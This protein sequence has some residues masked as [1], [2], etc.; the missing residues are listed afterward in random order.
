[1]FA[2]K[3]VCDSITPMGS[4]LVTI[5]ITYPRI[6]HSE[7]MTHRDRARNS[8]S[9]RAIPWTRMKS[10]VEENPFVPIVF[11]SEKRGMQPGEPVD[12]EECSKIWLAARDA[13]LEQASKLHNMGVHKSICNRLLEP[14]AWITVVMTATDWKNFFRL[15]VHP[16]AEI[17]FQQIAEM[18]QNTLNKSTPVE[19][20]WGRWHLPYIRGDDLI[21]ASNRNDTIDY[22][23]ILCRISA[24]RCARVS[25][26]THDGRRDHS[27]DLELFDRLV[28]GSGF[29]HWCYDSETEVLTKRG[30]VHWPK[31]VDGDELAQVDLRRA[32]ISFRRPVRIFRSNYEGLMYCVQGHAVDLCV[33]PNHRMVVSNRQSNGIWSDWYFRT[34]GSM[35]D[36]PVRYL[37]SGILEERESVEIPCLSELIGFWFGDGDSYCGKH[38]IRFSL[39]R[40][41]KID[42]LKKF[43]VV[44]YQGGR[45]YVD[46]KNLG[47]WF[48]INCFE[49]GKKCIPWK[50]L[51]ADESFVRGFLDGL[52][53]SDGSV[54]RKTWVFDNTNKQIIDFMQALLHLNGVSASLSVRE[55][56]GKHKSCYRLNVSDRISPRVEINQIS[57]SMSY[58]IEWKKY[59]G[60]I[61]CAEMPLGT[62]IVR[63]NNHV[64]VSGNSPMEHIATPATPDVKSGPF[65]GW[66]QYRKFFRNERAD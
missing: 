48:R 15:R 36:K 11:G 33:T 40:K 42:Y 39:R 41:R 60:M 27:K 35:G 37:K 6:I 57:R 30:W 56:Y 43:A 50:W 66:L 10:N 8:A 7:I 64:V 28:D 2:C 14:F 32:T 13:A 29:G 54:K 65:R 53:N 22:L 18:V 26:L 21:E 23:D 38:F 12:N 9:S 3:V 46:Q 62:V 59:S 5:E 24:A 19:V 51:T 20:G 47:E 16:D 63:R 55:G 49:A 31:V 17:H 1:M 58:E 4:R 25:Y 52:K 44:R 45:Y 61:Y 34:A